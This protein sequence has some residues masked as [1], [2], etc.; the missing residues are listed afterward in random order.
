MW[1]T[2]VL[3]VE[4]LNVNIRI[5]WAYELDGAVDLEFCDLVV[6]RY[7]ERVI[8]QLADVAFIVQVEALKGGEDFKKL[9][10]TACFLH[11]KQ[12]EAFLLHLV[13]IVE[14]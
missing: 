4:R 9:G 11:Q 13:E 2:L 12:L 5:D 14:N 7:A 6:G 3:N 10:E 1:W 8:L